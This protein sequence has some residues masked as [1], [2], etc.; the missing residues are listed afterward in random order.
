MGPTPLAGGPPEPPVATPARMEREPPVVGE[1]T[2]ILARVWARLE[3][4]LP[5]QRRLGRQPVYHRR[6]ILEAIVYVMRTDCGWSALPSTFPPWK[7]VYDLFV[8]WR[9]AGIWSEVWQGLKPPGPLPGEQL[10][11]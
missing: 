8:N 10:Q 7:T 3:P 9:R 1:P 11:L 5:A 2:D 6:R 4:L